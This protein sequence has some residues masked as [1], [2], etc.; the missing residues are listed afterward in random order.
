MS[1][2]AAAKPVYKMDPDLRL[3][4]RSTKH[5]MTSHNESEVIATAGLHM[6]PG[7][8]IMDIKDHIVVFKTDKLIGKTQMTLLK[9]FNNYQVFNTTKS[10]SLFTA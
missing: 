3:L 10:F 4:L 1:A 8:T 2:K 6:A 5:L 7:P 9:E